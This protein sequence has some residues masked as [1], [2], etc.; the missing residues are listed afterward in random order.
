M[1]GAGCKPPGARALFKG[2]AL[3]QAD[4][5]EEAVIQFEQ[6][7]R[8]LPME[9]RAWNFLGLAR[10]RVGD[11]EGAAQAY[12]KSVQLVG[13]RRYSSKHPSFVLEFNVGRLCLDR[14]RLLEAQRHLS[15]FASQNQS[16]PACYW[17]AE[18]YRANGH[19][20]AAVEM[21]NRALNSRSDSAVTWNRLGMVQLKLGRATNAIASFEKALKYRKDFPEARR[22]LAITYHRYAP[23]GLE[24]PEGLALQAFKDYLAL[25]PT[26]AA[27]VQRVADALESKLHP[28]HSAFERERTNQLT[29]ANTNAI[30]I[31]LIIPELPLKP[32]VESNIIAR[33]QFPSNNAAPGIV[34]RQNT[35]L[36]PDVVTNL[37]TAS[38]PSPPEK[39]VLITPSIPAISPKKKPVST[40]TKDK[41]PVKVAKASPTAVMPEKVRPKVPDVPG[42]ARYQYVSPARPRVGDNEKARKVF[43]Q[44]YHHHKLN[45]LDEAI[46]GYREVL[47]LDPG[48][49]QAHLNSAIAYQSKGEFRKALSGYELALAINPLSKISR[50]GFA[51]SLHRSEYY[52]D[53]AREF[54]KLLEVYEAYLPGHLELAIIYAGKL[55]M[56]NRAKMHYRRVLALNPQHPEAPVIRDWLLANNRP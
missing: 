21:L 41:P 13:E 18:S 49:Q 22:N 3:L 28:E 45:K 12:Q 27:A 43:D 5:P 55:K 10:H 46:L 54:E 7:T 31:P 15:T 51:Q 33:V 42:I 52:V 39:T 9:W 4:K 2:E 14:K 1:G 53:A 16:F 56:P 6:A 8:Y 23:K 19:H 38:K 11:L 50:Y 32:L 30:T 48:F 34:A 47:V 20:E 24:N 36:L 17:L 44:A 26:D 40:A 25:E 35:R 29:S 37:I